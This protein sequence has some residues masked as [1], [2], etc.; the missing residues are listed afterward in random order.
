MQTAKQDAF[1]EK[2]TLSSAISPEVRKATLTLLEK[3]Y[4]ARNRYTPLGPNEA[5]G[6]IHMLR[7]LMDQA[8]PKEERPLRW[9][10]AS[11]YAKARFYSKRGDKPHIRPSV[12]EVRWAQEHMPQGRKEGSAS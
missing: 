9:R 4:Y 2:L 8:P 7:T 10:V 3:G 5:A 1:I 12:E 11:L 6:V